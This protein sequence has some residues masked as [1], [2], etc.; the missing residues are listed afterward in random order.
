MIWPLE[1]ERPVLK[2]FLFKR[3]EFVM[4]VPIVIL[5]PV[6][7]L[8][9]QSAKEL[10]K[11]SVS[12]AW[13]PPSSRIQLASVFTDFES[14][15]S[16]R[17]HHVSSRWDNCWRDFQLLSCYLWWFAQ[18]LCL[19]DR[20]FWFL[21]SRWLLVE[22]IALWLTSGVKSETRLK[23]TVLRSIRKVRGFI[24]KIK[25]DGLWQVELPK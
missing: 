3:F 10:K 6:I 15:L 25:L 20:L 11:V 2:T 16:D 21:W 4:M 12:S 17:L 7:K 24:W 23:E 1:L 5:Y 8:Q 22:D 19:V 9:V 18:E 14:Y 13:D